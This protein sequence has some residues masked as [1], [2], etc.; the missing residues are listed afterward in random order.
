MKFLALLIMLF[1]ILGHAEG[2]CYSPSD[3]AAPLICS[4]LIDNIFPGTCIAKPGGNPP[5]YELQDAASSVSSS[6]ASTRVGWTSSSSTSSTSLS[7]TNIAKVRVVESSS[8]T[9]SSSSSSVETKED[10][11]NIFVRTGGSIAK[12]VK[13]VFCLFFC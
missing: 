1:P 7:A 4:S 10:T 13:W 6:S 3:C 5:L 2:A 11:G 8:S 9:S 12:A